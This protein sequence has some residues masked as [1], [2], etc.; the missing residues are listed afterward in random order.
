MRLGAGTIEGGLT[1]VKSESDIRLG[2][3]GL[4]GFRDLL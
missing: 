1:Y 4:H 2:G 3:S